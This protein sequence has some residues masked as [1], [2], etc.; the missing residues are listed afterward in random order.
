MWR[1]IAL[2]VLLFEPGR[3]FADPLEDFARW[4]REVGVRDSAIVLMQDGRRTGSRGAD[5]PFDLASNS[6]AITALCLRSL[7]AE[8]LVRWDMSLT[9]ALGRPAPPATLAEVMTHTSGIAPD[10]TQFGLRSWTK[11]PTPRHDEI[12]SRVLKRSKQAGTRGRYKYN[13]ENYAILGSVIERATGER[14][15]QVCHKRVLRPAGVTGTLSPHFGAFAA[16]GGWRMTMADYA[17]FQWHYFGPE[18]I[19]GRDP[20]A[21]PHAR[22]EKDVYYGPGM[23]FHATPGGWKVNHAGALLFLWGPRTGTYAVIFPDGRQAAVAY[24]K[25]VSRPRRLLKLDLALGGD[26]PSEGSE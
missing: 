18:G 8:G 13:N 21:Y 19:I 17:R 9:E 23:I 3:A 1:I 10:S 7:V 4:T 22:V 14:Y 20:L 6:K 11:N 5:V 12:T 26:A 25:A 16:W 2:A 15:T 24:D